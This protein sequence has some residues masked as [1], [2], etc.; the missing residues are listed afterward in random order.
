MS[1]RFTKGKG[2]FGSIATDSDADVGGDL[3]LAG[4]LAETFR[5]LEASPRAILVSR[6]LESRS[7]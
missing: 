3:S 5:S 1:T 2:L 4:D 7:A 6:F